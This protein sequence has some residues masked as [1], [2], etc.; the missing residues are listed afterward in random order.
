MSRKIIIGRPTY[1]Q[2]LAEIEYDQY[3]GNI[4]RLRQ[5]NGRARIDWYPGNISHDGG[6]YVVS[7]LGRTRTIA[8]VVW[9]LMTKEWSQTLVRHKDGNSF[10]NRWDN[11]TNLKAVDYGSL[12]F[13]R[14]NE[15]L[16]YDPLTGLFKWKNRPRLNQDWFHGNYRVKEDRY[17]YFSLQIDA[18]HYHASRVAF[19]LMEGYWPPHQ[20]DHKDGNSLN[21]IYRN[22]RPAT[23]TQNM[24]N[25][26]VRLNNKL[27]VKG[28][29]QK[30][31]G[32]YEARIKIDKRDYSLGIYDTIEKASHRYDEVAKNVHGEFFYKNSR[33][34]CQVNG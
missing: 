2:V 9:L 23:H 31:N 16:E 17:E 25:K 10:N 18:R 4:R 1:E 21:N 20:I 13:E 32:R 19:L 15:C 29:R 27:G 3:T 8:D 28:V 12:T 22:L 33:E 5:T 24:F 14:A 34:E 26:V 11:L 7:I 6:H 30:R